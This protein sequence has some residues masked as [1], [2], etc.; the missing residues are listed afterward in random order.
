MLVARAINNDVRVLTDVDSVAE[1]LEQMEL[2]GADCLPVVNQSSRKVIGQISRSILGDI[3]DNTISLGDLE[4]EEPFKIFNG[5]HLF[6]AIRM[7]LQHELRFLPVVNE[8]WEFQ[9]IIKKQQVL[10]SLS[11]ML[12]L[13]EYG[14]VITIELSH[15]NFTLSEIVQLIEAE[16]GKILG[17]TV[18]TPDAEKKSYEISIKLNLQDV[19]RVASALRRYGYTILTESESESYNIDLETRAD[20]LMKYIDM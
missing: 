7:M 3:D 17:I 13:T 2:L 18:E 8:N 1:A 6:H 10:E 5:Q 9:G 12:N 4:L 15:R 11:K 19:S 14:S 16:G 20:E